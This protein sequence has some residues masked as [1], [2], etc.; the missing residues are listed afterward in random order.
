MKRMIGIL[1]DTHDN[2]DAVRSAVR[3]FQD[4]GC[5]LIIHAGDFVAPFAARELGRAGI[6]LQAVYGNCDGEKLGLAD[7]ISP[8]GAIQEPPLFFDNAGRSFIVVHKDSDA[9]KHIRAGG[10][11]VIVYGHTH[12]TEV[13]RE[14][15]TLIVNPGEVGG[16]VTGV[17]SVALLD[18][19]TLDA[20]IIT[21]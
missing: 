20:E 11:D 2:M 12:R 18:P 6:P 21:L 8:F 7:V 19:A 10:K 16:W 4:A 13:R 3:L 5:V 15:R 14:G 17:R 1:S 9:R